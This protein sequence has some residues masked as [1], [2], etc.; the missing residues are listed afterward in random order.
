MRQQRQDGAAQPFLAFFELLPVALHPLAIVDDFGNLQFARQRAL[1]AHFGRMGGED[2]TDERAIEEG[3][4]GFGVDAGFARAPESIRHRADARRR[5]RHDMGAVAPDVMLVFGDIGQ[6]REIAEGAHDRQSLVGGQTVEDRFQFAPRAKLIV[7]ME[8]NGGL[9]DALDNLE[10]GRALLLAHRIAENAP[11]QPDVVAQ[12]KILFVFRR[13]R[14]LG[15]R[16]ARLS[17]DI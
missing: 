13:L 1:A 12:G 3:A 4:Q 15:A 10:H 7:A 11:E 16:L 5:A 17:G 8:A 6:V 2:G 14:R 9:A